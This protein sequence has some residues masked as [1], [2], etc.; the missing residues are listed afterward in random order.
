VD[1]VLRAEVLGEVEAQIFLRGQINFVQD[2]AGLCDGEAGK[3]FVDFVEEI[4]C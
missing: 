1:S 4:L 2:F 3:R